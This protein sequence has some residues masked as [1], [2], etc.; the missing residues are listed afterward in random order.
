[1]KKILLLGGSRYLLP[2]IKKI[3]EMGH[4]AITCDYLPKNIAHQ[5][6]DEYVNASI[7]DKDT[8]LKIARSKN[9]DGI[10]SFATDPGVVTA[11]YVAEKMNLP[12]AGGYESVKILQNKDLFRKFLK[13]HSFNV[14][15][16]RS[17]TNYNDAVKDIKSGELKFPLMV[18]PVDS[19]GSKGVSR[20]D[21]F[22]ELNEAI[23]LALNNSISGK[24]LLESYLEKVGCSSDSDC[25]SVNGKLVVT[26]FS[27]QYFDPEALNPYTPSAYTWPSTLTEEHKFQLES[28]LN[29]LL[30]LLNM[31]TGIYNVET[32]E[33]SDG[34]AYIM[35]VSPR[36]GGNRLA[37]IVGNEIGVDLIRLSILAAIGEPIPEIIKPHPVKGR[38]VNLLLYSNKDGVFQ[39]LQ[40]ADEI[41]NNIKDI[42]L[43]VSPGERVEPFSG[44]NKTIGFATLSFAT[45]NEF[46]IIKN[47]LNRLIIADVI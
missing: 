14:P 43:W 20:V 28:E 29:R 47:K 40:I 34:K 13:E 3:H 19:A 39:G 27:A 7:I 4:Y 23:V 1:M 25:F 8:I 18:K 17:Y 5:F 45:E 16:A 11:A 42:D 38:V 36:G 46:A 9:V 26:T 30:K 32:R 21:K 35:E 31:R 6:S 15:E 41:K 10:M 37:E 12:F 33:C 22:S 44:A 24:F 2:V